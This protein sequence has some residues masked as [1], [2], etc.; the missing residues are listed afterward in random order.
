MRRTL[1]AFREATGNYS[2]DWYSPIV[3]AI[4]NIGVSIILAKHFGLAGVFLGTIISSLFTN[5]W[6]EPLVVS[7]KSLT[8]GVKEY[9]LQYFRYT[10]LTVCICIAVYGINSIFIGN[11][12]IIFACKALISLI[13]PNIILI[14]IYRKDKKFI[15]YT[16]YIKEKIFK[17]K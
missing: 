17:R 3:E 6:I 16:N 10:L 1:M 15:F 13:V 7:K 2:Q 14:V 5:F 4:T 8:F 11:S 12:F 9:L